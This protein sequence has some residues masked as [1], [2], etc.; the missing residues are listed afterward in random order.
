MRYYR[1]SGKLVA[2]LSMAGAATLVVAG[3]SSSSD[4]AA[5]ASPTPE[6][7]ATSASPSGSPTSTGGGSAT[8]TK[9]S[10]AGAIPDGANIVKFNCGSTG[11]GEIA[12]VQFK[13]GPTVLFLETKNGAWEVIDSD[14]VCGTASAGL[15]PEVLAYCSTGQSS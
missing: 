8:C 14:R 2:A 5:S 6:Q 13:P 12:A 4:N 3:C 1:K 15:P 9:E 11:G 7:T 10:I